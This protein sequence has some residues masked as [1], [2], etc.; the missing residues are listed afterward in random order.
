[1]REVSW[2][3]LCIVETIDFKLKLRQTV[4]N[5]FKVFSARI[6]FVLF[7]ARRLPRHDIWQLF[8]QRASLTFASEILWRSGEDRM[9]GTPPVC[10]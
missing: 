6:I 10:V 5:A 8:N 3:V 1:M 7:D 9:T 4:Y 2:S